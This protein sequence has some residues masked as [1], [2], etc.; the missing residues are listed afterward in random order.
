[1]TADAESPI[2][3]ANVANRTRR[4]RYGGEFPLILTIGA[5]ASVP[6]FTYLIITRPP[7]DQSK[8]LLAVLLMIGGAAAGC[9]GLWERFLPPRF[10][11]LRDDTI[12]LPR[13][14]WSRESV[15]LPFDELR[16]DEGSVKGSPFL[17]LKHEGKTYH[18]SWRV[19][20][21]EDHYLE[22]RERLLG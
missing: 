22:L 21:S 3:E 18:I 9:L 13:H 4:Y 14:H 20:D 5:L 15:T 7:A 19:L 10:I 11:I 8:T 12:E 16:V 1:M 6:I 17:R 2:Q